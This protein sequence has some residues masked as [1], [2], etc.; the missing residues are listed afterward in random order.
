MHERTHRNHQLH[1]NTTEDAP[2]E[3]ALP[4]CHLPAIL[5]LSRYQEEDYSNSEPREEEGRP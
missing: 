2:D 4:L 3:S 1:I 5:K